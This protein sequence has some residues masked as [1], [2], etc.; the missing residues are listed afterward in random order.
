MKK[1]LLGLVTLLLFVGCATTE[2][3]STKKIKPVVLEELAIF[4]QDSYID[5]D[6]STVKF[7]FKALR[8]DLVDFYIGE[9]KDNLKLVQEDVLVGTRGLEISN[10]EANREY[11]YQIVAKRDKKSVKSNII[12]FTKLGNTNNWEVPAWGSKAVFYEIFVRSFSD[13]NGDGIGDFIGL[14]NK[15]PYLKE[16]G[17]DA[18]WLMPINQSPSYHGY[19]VYDYYDVEMDYGTLDEF[20]DLLNEAHANGIKIIMDLV[21]NH[22][23]TEHPWFQNAASSV[24]SEY[25]DYYDWADATD[26]IKKS[27]PFGGNQWHKSNTGYYNG[28]F[29]SGMPDM[30]LRNKKVRDEFK[31]IASFWL[32]MGVDGFRLDAALHI[33]DTD[34]DVSHNWWQE[35]NTHVKSVNPNAL[36]VGENWA[37]T[38][39]MAS[40]FEDLEASFNF[41]FANNILEMSRG[42][43][44]DLLGTL[45]SIHR[46]Y[47]K[48]NPNFIDATFI[49]NHDQDRVA[50]VLGGNKTKEKFAAS[51]LLTLPGTPFLYYGEE[52]GMLG[53]KP[54]DNIREP[55]DWYKSAKGEGMTTMSKGGFY[56][57]MLYTKANDGISYEEQVGVEGSTLEHYKKLIEI[58]KSNPEFFSS[59]NYTK[60]ELSED[61]YS[62]EVKTEASK[63][64]VIHNYNKEDKSFTLDSSVTDLLT[65][66]TYQAKDN[67][68]IPAFTSLIL[69]Y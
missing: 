5:I 32:N 57:S 24:D 56:N 17:I 64:L 37:S 1:I 35:F 60:V 25:R 68:T 4:D 40:F 2:V 62:Y 3:T 20:K 55:M 45:G 7:L 16:L 48:Y 13:G 52:L 47:A 30:N 41:S 61:L 50:S 18:L 26:N 44:V 42:K 11:F 8:G 29:W 43:K 65:D 14:K 58:R 27:G 38:N 31:D 9:S 66:N 28:V 63:I 69:G 12:S 6:D 34:K 15:I 51:I 54:D 53:K 59:E 49:T 39:Q 46:A 67:I 36:L 23:S 21:I 10:L 22:S 19:D 33:D